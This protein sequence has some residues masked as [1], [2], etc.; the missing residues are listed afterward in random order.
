MTWT[1]AQIKTAYQALSPLPA[2]LTDAVNQLNAQTA[3]GYVDVP[4]AAIRDVLLTTGEWGG[5]VVASSAATTA[6]GIAAIIESLRTLVTT[7]GTVRATQAAVRS[8]VPSWLGDLQTAGLLAS[9][10]VSA[11]EGMMTATLPVWAPALQVADLQT[12]LAQ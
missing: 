8:K 7:N 10:T 1:Y 9:G 6:S 3:S 4:A 12:A 5:L 11:L 2:T